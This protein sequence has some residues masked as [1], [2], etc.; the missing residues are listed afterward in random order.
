MTYL[1]TGGTGMIGSRIVR[2]LAR[3]GEQ[4]CSLGLVSRVASRQGAPP[5][6][7]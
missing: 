2:N 1:V 5:L 6:T 7:R 4:V 3:E